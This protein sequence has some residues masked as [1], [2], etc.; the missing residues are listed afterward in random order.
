MKPYSD[1]IESD[2]QQ[3]ISDRVRERGDLDYKQSDAL[4]AR[5]TI[6]REQVVAE[7]SRDVSAMANSNGGVILY[8]VEERKHLPVRMDAGL[9]PGEKG[10]PSHEWLEQ[11]IRGNIRPAPDELL[12]RPI[13]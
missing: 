2:V 9:R 12:I 10:E 5:P 3:L 1:W 4:R 6:S 8:G 13:E 11:V 7:I